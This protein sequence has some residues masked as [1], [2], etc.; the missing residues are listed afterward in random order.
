MHKIVSILCCLCVLLL[1]EETLS[2][3]Q[4]DGVVIQIHRSPKRTV[5]VNASLAKL[6]ALAGG[7][8]VAVPSTPTKEALPE[9]MRHLPTCGSPRGASLEQIVAFQ[10]DFVLL[11]ARVPSHRQTAELLRNMNIDALC[12]SY[13]NYRDFRELTALFADIHRKNVQELPELTNTL[14]ECEQIIASAKDRTGPTVA[15][16][17]ASSHG[18][19][20]ENA[21]T[22]TGHMV[23]LLG[24]RNIVPGE[25]EARMPFSY[26]TFLAADP[27]VV[28]LVPMGKFPMLKEKFEKELATL[29]AWGN[30]KAAKAGRVHFLP[31]EL[32]L[33]TPGPEFPQAFRHL[34]PLLYPEASKP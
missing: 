14:H 30:L 22:N 12:V 34:V 3:K 21:G 25:S 8:A 31:A 24:G 10:P 23:K 11:S 20:A 17:L 1:S 27:D 33:Y 4:P 29:P 13:V 2:Y 6:W 26:E 15:I 19:Q 28:L 7:T 9:S 5:I 18:F 32:F 16:L